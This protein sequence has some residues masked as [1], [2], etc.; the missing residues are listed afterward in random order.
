MSI[1]IK[2]FVFEARSSHLFCLV[3]GLGEAFIELRK[4]SPELLRSISFD[5]WRTGPD[6][7]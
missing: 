5:R 3:P 7:R 1:T 4:P 2:R 6:H